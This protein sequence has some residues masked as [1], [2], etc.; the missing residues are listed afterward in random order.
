VP[1]LRKQGAPDPPL[2]EVS[3]KIEK[4]VIEQRI[5]ELLNDWLQT[6]RSQAH[7][8]KMNGADAALGAELFGTS[9]SKVSDKVGAANSGAK[10]GTG[11]QLKPGANK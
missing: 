5:D 11:T 8:E 1:E 4:I 3:E 7:I 2:N 9:G 10:T 6:L